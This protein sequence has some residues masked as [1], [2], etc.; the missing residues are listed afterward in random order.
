[1]ET[2]NDA[3]SALISSGVNSGGALDPEALTLGQAWGDAFTATSRPPDTIWLSSA[4]VGEFIDAKADGG[5][6][7]L[8]SQLSANFTAGGG[9]GGSIS[10]LR[11]VHVPA[12]NATSID[13][14]VGPSTGFAWAEDGT[15]TLQVDVPA[16][17]GR[18]V[19]IIGM[20]WFAPLYP[21]AFTAYSVGSGGS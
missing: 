16:R 14:I 9:V 2:E 11:A 10:G 20:A 3:V 8:Y 7:P 4:A 18:D 5:N 6:A 12:L 15:Y 13:V 21:A 17:A 19:A 1:M